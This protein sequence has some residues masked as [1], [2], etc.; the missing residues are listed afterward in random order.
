MPTVNVAAYP[1]VL[2]NNQVAI[3]N[4]TLMG[5]G[6]SFHVVPEI[7]EDLAAGRLVR[8]LPD[9]TLPPVAVAALM[10]S[11]TRQPSKIRM[12]VDALRA[13]LEPKLPADTETRTPRSKQ[14]SRQ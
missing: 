10:P 2:S 6:M 13:Y 1:R 5:L 3:R 9:W 12:A 11:R 4:L 7:A 14:R 8:V